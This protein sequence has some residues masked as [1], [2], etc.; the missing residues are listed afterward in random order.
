[1]YRDEEAK[2]SIRAQGL[3]LES[4]YCLFKQT[5][6]GALNKNKWNTTTD[7]MANVIIIQAI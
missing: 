7:F 5:T 3:I 1:M 2:F 6:S 4:G